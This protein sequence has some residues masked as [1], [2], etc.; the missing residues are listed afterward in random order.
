MM[1]SCHVDSLLKDRGYRSRRQLALEI[2]MSPWALGFLARNK[3]KAVSFKTAG[4]SL[5]P[6]PYF[7]LLAI[8]LGLGCR[9]SR[10]LRMSAHPVGWKAPGRDGCRS[11]ASFAARCC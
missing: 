3:Y 1:I 4:Y 11:R 5:G 6:Y 9:E 7:I 10:S 8:G 2:G